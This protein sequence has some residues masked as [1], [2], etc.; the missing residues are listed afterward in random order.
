MKPGRGHAI[1]DDAGPGLAGGVVI[2]IDLG[3]G[4][5]GSGMV[6]ATAVPM[7]CVEATTVIVMIGVVVTTVVTMTGV[8]MMAVIMIVT[9]MR[10]MVMTGGRIAGSAHAHGH[11]IGDLI[12]GVGELIASGNIRGYPTRTLGRQCLDNAHNHPR[13]DFVNVIASFRVILFGCGLK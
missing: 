11:E 7:I 4:E 13:N 6:V 8:V 10:V 9:V 3:P 1:K 2:G 5:S 12:V